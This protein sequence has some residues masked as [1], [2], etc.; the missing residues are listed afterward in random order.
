MENRLLNSDLATL[1]QEL[2]K[3]QN[4]MNVSITT[5]YSLTTIYNIV[6]RRT[7]VTKRNKP[8]LIGLTAELEIRMEYINKLILKTRNL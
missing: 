3:T 6:Y 7:R 1:F 5:G 2:L 8:V 4:F